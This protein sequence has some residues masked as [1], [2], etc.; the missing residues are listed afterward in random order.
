MRRSALIMVYTAFFLVHFFCFTG[1]DHTCV[2]TASPAYN[3]E[4]GKLKTLT[5]KNERSKKTKVRLNKRFQLALAGP[6]VNSLTD[7]PIQYL[8]A[9]KP[10]STQ[11]YLLIS[12]ILA[13]SLRGPPTL[14]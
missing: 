2:T 9:I 12:V 10:A 13:A 11:D 14:S 7:L 3:N 6:A 1:R 4:T 8:D 5:A